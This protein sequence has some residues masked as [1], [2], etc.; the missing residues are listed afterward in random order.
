MQVKLFVLDRGHSYAVPGGPVSC[1]RYGLRARFHWL[2]VVLDIQTLYL[3]F[4]KTEE[5]SETVTNDSIL[6][7]A[8]G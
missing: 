6:I 5:Q 8:A 1:L 7:Y 3:V 4:A 2:T